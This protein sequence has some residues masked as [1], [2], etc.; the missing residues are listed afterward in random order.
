[1][2]VRFLCEINNNNN[3]ITNKNFFL[4]KLANDISNGFKNLNQNQIEAFC[5]GLFN[6]SYNYHDFKQLIRD[7]LIN[8]KSFF[9][10]ARYSSSSSVLIIQ[11]YF[12]P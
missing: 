6:K 2:Q 12:S 4:N 3:V 5:L 1:M 10:N 8:L 9:V 7:F 11:R